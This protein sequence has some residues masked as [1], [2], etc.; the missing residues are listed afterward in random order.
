MNDSEKLK[1]AIKSLKMIS[2]VLDNIQYELEARVYTC[3]EDNF[4]DIFFCRDEADWALR[5]IEI[6]E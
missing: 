2:R 4:T 5:K 1:I 3:D 6:E